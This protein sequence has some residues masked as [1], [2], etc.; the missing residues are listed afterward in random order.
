MKGPI[1]KAPRHNAGTHA[2]VHDQIKRKIFDE[3]LSSMLQR[4]LIKRVQDCMASSIDGT[5]RTLGLLLAI[6]CRHTAESALMDSPIFSAG[7]WN[8]VT[9]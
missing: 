1:I 5:A 9:F 3:K 7:K 6:M 8:P 4:L 2:R